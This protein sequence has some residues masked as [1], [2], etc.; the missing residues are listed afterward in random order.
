[1]LVPFLTCPRMQPLGLAPMYPANSGR[2]FGSSAKC[3][4]AGRYADLTEGDDMIEPGAAPGGNA[5]SRKARGDYERNRE[6][7]HGGAAMRHADQPRFCGEGGGGS[8]G[9][10][11]DRGFYP[12]RQHQP[13]NSEG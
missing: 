7:D 12:M 9:A 1:M 4:V 13:H 11:E 3:L 8:G 10:S 6:Q 2:G 5:T